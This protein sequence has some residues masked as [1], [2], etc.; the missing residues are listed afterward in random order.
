LS[1]DLL[2]L[3]DL[4]LVN[5]LVEKARKLDRLEATLNDT[6]E[7]DRRVIERLAKTFYSG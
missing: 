7:P 6:S 5:G 4:E 3:K 2:A 1:R